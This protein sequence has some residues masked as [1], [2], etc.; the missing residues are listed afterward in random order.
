MSRTPSLL[1]S[2]LNSISTAT[3]LARSDVEILCSWNGSDE[4][5]QAIKNTS[6]YNFE[7]KQRVPYHFSG[8]MNALASESKGEILLI[9]NDDIII[10]KKGID[11]G[12]EMLLK[13]TNIGLIGALLRSKSNKLQHAGFMFGNDLIPYHFLEDLIDIEEFAHE[14]QFLTMAAVTGAMLL[15]RRSDFQC[16]LFN[17]RY[18]RCGEDVELSLDMREILQKSVLLCTSFSAVHYQCAT[19]A[20]QQEMGNEPDDIEQMKQRRRD[21]LNQ[22]NNKMLREEIALATIVAEASFKKINEQQKHLNKCLDIERKYHQLNLE[23]LDLK[24]QLEQNQ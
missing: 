7:I 17:E 1:S 2:L 23:V 8:N 22:A 19:R 20:K 10:D 12:I 24:E 4:D 15:T 11:Y 13:N 18:N 5:E 21:F 16:L 3:Q 6:G 9:V 14:H